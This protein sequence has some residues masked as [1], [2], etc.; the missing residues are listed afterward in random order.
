MVPKRIVDELEMR[1]LSVLIE[2]AAT[3]ASSCGKE[4]VQV[5]TQ[6]A[7]YSARHLRD[8]SARRDPKSS[9]GSE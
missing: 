8:L 7:F 2:L 1:N 5:T 6:D 4:F 9:I 3:I